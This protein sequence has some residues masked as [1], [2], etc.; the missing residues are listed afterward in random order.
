MTPKKD[1][2]AIVKAA[3]EQ[4]FQVRRTSRGHYHF[5]RPNGDYVCDIGGTPSV[6]EVTRKR[7]KLRHAGLQS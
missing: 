2:A 6:T 5:W 4:G 3:E 7:A 1:V